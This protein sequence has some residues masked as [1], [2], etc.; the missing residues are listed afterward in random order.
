MGVGELREGVVC[1]LFYFLLLI[2]R[3]VRRRRFGNLAS[4]TRG[5]LFGRLFRIV[6]I[7]IFVEVTPHLKKAMPRHLCWHDLQCG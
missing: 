3:C 6:I 7:I 5:I 2:A 1:F 4:E